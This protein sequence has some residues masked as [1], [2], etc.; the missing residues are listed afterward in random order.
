[1]KKVLTGSLICILLSGCSLIPG[2][3]RP[4]VTA[5]AD[6][7]NGT[8]SDQ[9]IAPDWWKSF[10]SAELN[11][12]MAEALDQNN[13]LRAALDR[14]EQARAQEQIAGSS[15]L[16][17]VDA[18]AGASVSRTKAS[19]NGKA[20]YKRGPSAGLNI[21]YELDLFGANRAHAEAAESN[22]KGSIYDQQALALTT[23][24]DVANAYF[25]VINLRERVAISQKN[26]DSFQ[27]ILRIVNARFEAGAS[28]ALD[29]A[30]QK[31]TLASAQ[32]SLA[33]LHKQGAQAENALAVLLGRTP[34]NLAVQA[35]SLEDLHIPVLSPVQPAKLVERR[36][37]VRSAEASLIAANAD[38]GVAR[39]AFF[40]T[41]D[42]GAGLSLAAASFTGGPLTTVVSGTSSLLAPIFSGGLLE[43]NLL[44]S[45]ARKAELVENYRK[46]VL[47]SF[48]EV[49]DALAAVKAAEARETA[50]KE[51]VA[52]AQKSYNLSRELY[53]SGAVDF[54]T[55]LNAQ[56][57]LLNTEDNFASVR[58]ESLQASVDLYKAL[59]G[60]WQSEEPVTADAVGANAPVTESETASP[61]KK[62]D[63]MTAGPG[64]DALN[65]SVPA[66]APAKT[67]P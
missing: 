50:L 46:S 6:W 65:Q 60:G 9:V 25:L 23:M 38:I 26:L 29:V 47:T 16:P 54:E 56:Q 12:F 49:E 64:P 44:L 30:Q 14:I 51:A 4:N 43:G 63:A 33:T 53:N 11:Q 28:S 61:S 35:S 19:N 22:Y 48:Q 58:L 20:A 42:L 36:P 21:S 13:D 57:A 67:T 39:A 7:K 1:M 32:A 45:K 17:S 27:D 40:P 41:V 8:A 24:A 10:N 5:A 2:Y 15:L 66:T 52:E 55:L 62:I 37:D 59:G 34:E 18:S 3:E 31:T